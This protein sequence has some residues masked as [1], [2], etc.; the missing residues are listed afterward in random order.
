MDTPLT[1]WQ[2]Y[3]KKLGETRPW[4]VLNPNVERSSEE[5]AERRMSICVECPSLLKLTNQC[6]E[7]GCVMSLKTKLEKATCPLGKW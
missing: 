3:K 5:E 1:A 4:D 7:C 2:E 6:K